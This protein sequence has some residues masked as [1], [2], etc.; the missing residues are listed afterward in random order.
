VVEI[1]QKRFLSFPVM[2]AMG[3]VLSVK[4]EENGKI[5]NGS[6]YSGKQFP[7]EDVRVWT[8]WSI[9]SSFETRSS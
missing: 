1:T 8:A 3:M 6:L 2:G 9:F 4:E 7:K 5:C